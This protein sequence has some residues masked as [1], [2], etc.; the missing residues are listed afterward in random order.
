MFNLPPLPMLMGFKVVVTTCQAADI[1]VQARVTNRDLVSLQGNLAK[2][3]Y[4]GSHQNSIPLHWTALIVDEAAQATEPENLIP[5][6]VVAPPATPS[7]Q[8]PVFVMAGD[9]HQLNPRT[10][11]RFTTLPTSLF[12]RL[13]EISVYA[14]HPLARKR[15][16]R[17][18]HRLP[19][20]RPP[21]VNLI[22]NYRSH[23]AILAVP[24]SLFYSNTLIPEASQTDTLLPFTGWAGRRWPVLFACNAGIDSCEDIVG[25]GRGWY[26]M[27]EA[28]KAIAYAQSLLGQGLINNQSEICIMSP[29][30]AQVNLLR[31]LAR[32]SELFDINIGPME[33]FQGLESRFVIVC[34]T[35]A[36]KRFLDEDRVR[37]IGLVNEKKKF[38]VAITRAKEGLVVLGNPWVLAVEPCWL[39]F[40]EFCWRNGLWQPETSESA[41]TQGVEE[42]FV[43]EWKLGPQSST[44]SGLEAALLY[45]ESDKSAGSQA[46]KKFMGGGES[47]EDALWRSGMEAQEAI[48]ASISLTGV[49]AEQ[50]SQL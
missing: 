17:I 50:L 18:S 33:A 13:S 41:P 8:S 30:Q 36:R 19:M 26:N 25:R 28:Q 45:K 37:G 2:N 31:K 32:Q 1:L 15:L 10:Y 11:S 14:S 16:H 21:F 48:D 44:P 39:A 6:S 47:M 40:L 3:I 5:L 4:P 23:P 42:T 38:N 27:R 43:D 46:A 49:T 7:C 34:T 24:S 35:R 20:L 22:R 9:Q 12:E 29:F